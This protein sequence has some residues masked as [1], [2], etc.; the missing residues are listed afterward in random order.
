MAVGLLA[1]VC[2][3]LLRWSQ[4]SPPVT[5]PNA[6]MIASTTSAPIAAAP[7]APTSGSLT[8]P[9]RVVLMASRGPAAPAPGLHGRELQQLLSLAPPADPGRF[10]PGPE[11]PLGLTALDDPDIDAARAAG[12]SFER[13]EGRAATQMFGIRDEALK[14]VYV[15]DR[16]GST[17]DPPGRDVLTAEKSELLASL[18]DLNASQQFQ[19]IVYNH[20]PRVFQPDTPGARLMFATEENKEAVRKFLRGVESDG[21]TA[22]DVALALA[23]RMQPDVIFFLSDADRPKLTPWQLE[24]LQRM[25]AGIRIHTVQF[26]VEPRADAESFM[27]ELAR[28]N[29]GQ[30]KYIPLSELKDGGGR[31]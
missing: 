19:I 23:I 6:D 2:V 25:A 16:S 26:G 15:I 8:E 10:L 7:A 5:H 14:F 4:P 1:A 3:V 11:G 20:A 9:R 17:S 18:A 13:R 28:Q 31:P 29:D 12:R 22:H 30:F 21:E 27:R 24:H